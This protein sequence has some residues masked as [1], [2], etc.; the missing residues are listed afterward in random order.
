MKDP[1]EAEMIELLSK[2]GK[3]V[4]GSKALILKVTWDT[5]IGETREYIEMDIQTAYEI[6]VL[7]GL[8]RARQ[9]RGKAKKRSTKAQKARLK[10][11]KRK[12]KD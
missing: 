5:A 9:A 1:T 8:I 2:A 7:P 3:I 10:A 12:S 4:R 6:Y 11:E